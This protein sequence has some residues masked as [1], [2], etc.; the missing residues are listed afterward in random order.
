M[1]GA[2]LALAGGCGDNNP[3]PAYGVPDGLHAV[4]KKV[5]GIDAAYGLPDGYKKIDIGAQP[6]YSVPMDRG[7]KIDAGAATLYSVQMPD[8]AK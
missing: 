3:A 5:G 8:R 6:P 4:D 7:N 2:G 1:L